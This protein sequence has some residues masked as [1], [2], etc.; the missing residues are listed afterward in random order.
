MFWCILMLIVFIL[1]IPM[2]IYF[3]RSTN[4]HYECDPFDIHSDVIPYVFGVY[5][6]VVGV[7]LMGVLIASKL[8]WL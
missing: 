6:C 1:G 2:N 4:K 3:I 7:A 5:W 8:H